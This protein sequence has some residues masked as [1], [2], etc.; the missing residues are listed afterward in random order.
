MEDYRN[1]PHGKTSNNRPEPWRGLDATR[2]LVKALNTAA[3]AIEIYG[4][5]HE[6]TATDIQVLVPRQLTYREARDA[7]IEYRKDR[8]ERIAI[9][10]DPALDAEQREITVEVLRAEAHLI[11]LGEL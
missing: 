4:G 2:R 10:G 1:N 11:E 9:H 7:A 5:Y 8:L 6:L 3:D